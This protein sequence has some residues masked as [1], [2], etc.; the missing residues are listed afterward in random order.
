VAGVSRAQF[1]ATLARTAEK[2]GVVLQSIEIQGADEDFPTLD[3]EG[4]FKLALVRRS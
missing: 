3:G 1:A 4:P 2:C